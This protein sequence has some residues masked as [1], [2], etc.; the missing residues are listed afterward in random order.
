MQTAVRWT[1]SPNCHPAFVN[2]RR[3]GGLKAGNIVAP[4]A[5]AAV[6]QRLRPGTQCFRHGDIGGEIIAAPMSRAT[7]DRPP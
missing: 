5:E 6:G 7:A 2:I 3:S 4:E 1:D